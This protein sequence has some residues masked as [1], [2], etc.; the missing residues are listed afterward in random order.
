MRGGVPA[1]LLSFN[2]WLTL[3]IST[4]LWVRSSSD[5]IPVSSMMDGLTVTGATG[6][7]WRMNHSGLAVS[8]L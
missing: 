2:L 4:N 8:G 1:S 7:T 3:I 6:N 5:L